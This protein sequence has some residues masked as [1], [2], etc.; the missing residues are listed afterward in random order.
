MHLRGLDINLL[1]ALDALMKERSITRAAEQLNLSQSGMS[2]ALRRLRDFFNDPLLV[3]IGRNMVLTPLGESLVGPVHGIIMQ[4]KTLIDHT[5]GFD[6]KTT[7]RQITIMASDYVGVVFLADLLKR[8]QIAAPRISVDLV[9]Q[10]DQYHGPL[11][12]G[13]VDIL[14]IPRQTL[15][16]EHPSAPLFEDDYVCIAWAENADF[17]GEL[18]YEKYMKSHHVITKLGKAR[19]PAFDSW[20]FQRFDRQRIVDVVAPSFTLVPHYVVGTNR[21]AT[22]HARM[23][24]IYSRFF[25]L[26]IVKAP[27]EIPRVFEYIQWH[28]YADK[29]PATLW[30][31]DLM[32]EVARGLPTPERG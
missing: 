24:E 18:T 19:T 20:L 30:L 10:E 21:I 11:D 22:V 14:I 9:L 29:H 27:F 28:R 26:R 12:R 32:V 8:L 25:P 4:A 2:T 31:R 13:E 17:E 7:E 5:P 3:P 1:I 23:A 15:S 16:T 6:P